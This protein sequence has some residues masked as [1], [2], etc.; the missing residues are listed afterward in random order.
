[1]PRRCSR[2]GEGAKRLG[3]NSQG[4]Q[5]WQSVDL[6]TAQGRILK[7]I[8]P[9]ARH[10][11]EGLNRGEV[12]GFSHRRGERILLQPLPMLAWAVCDGLNLAGGVAEL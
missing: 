6:Q 9:P 12:I 2:P 10:G 7:V 4:L 5:P 1:M 8:S 11:P 3:K